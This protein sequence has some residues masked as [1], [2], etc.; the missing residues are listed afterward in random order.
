MRED[1]E[2]ATK[3][4]ENPRFSV[5]TATGLLRGCGT[6]AQRLSRPFDQFRVDLLLDLNALR[7][8]ASFRQEGASG[9]STEALD[10]TSEAVREE[11]LR[12]HE[13]RDDPGTV[14]F[15]IG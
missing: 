4:H 2:S 10:S 8:Y 5:S 1:T 12:P 7:Y 13:R 11:A 6:F 14:E 15:V 3:V 9:E